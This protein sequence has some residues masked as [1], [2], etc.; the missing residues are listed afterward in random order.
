MTSHGVE[1]RWRNEWVDGWMDGMM[2][3]LWVRCSGYAG[4]S[5]CPV[6]QSTP[7]ISSKSAR[8]WAANQSAPH[9]GGGGTV[10]GL[11]MK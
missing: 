2:R 6:T 8:G 10:N 9:P 11:F 1:N 3:F 4:V 5:A 7:G